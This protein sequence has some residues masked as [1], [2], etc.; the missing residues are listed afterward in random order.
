MGERDGKTRLREERKKIETHDNKRKRE[1]GRTPE[2]GKA[3]R[4][5]GNEE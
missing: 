4:G 2:E 3:R 5:K 1:R